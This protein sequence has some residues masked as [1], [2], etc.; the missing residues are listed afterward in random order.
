[1]S[2]IQPLPSSTAA[3]YVNEK[4]MHAA[5]K[6][7]TNSALSRNSDTTTKDTESESAVYEARISALKSSTTYTADMEK[8]KQMKEESDQRMAG[9]FKQTVTESSLKQFGNIKNIYARLAQGEEVNGVKVTAEEIAQAKADV[10]EGGYWSAEAT[11]DRFLDFAKALSGGDSSKADLLLDAFKE[12]YAAATEAWGGELPEISKN[13][14]D[15][16]LKKFDAWKNGTEN[17]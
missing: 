14:Y 15:M 13:T 10:A 6:S 2:S 9:L 7:N 5:E 17:E 16:T 4:K 8:I 3:A 11:S 1:M 12:G